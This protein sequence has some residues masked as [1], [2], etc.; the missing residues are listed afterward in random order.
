MRTLSLAIAL[1]LASLST[2]AQ[3]AA[4]IQV[5]PSN[6]AGWQGNDAGAWVNAAIASLP[7][8]GGNVY[9]G[10]GTYTFST[11]I[12]LNKNVSLHGAGS[13]FTI[14]RYTGSGDAIRMQAGSQPPYMNGSITGI[15]L[16]GNSNPTAVGIHHI[17]TIGSIYDDVTVENFTGAGGTGMW[18]DNQAQF[19]ERLSLRKLSVYRNTIGWR[20]TNSNPSPAKSNSFSYWRV[21]EVHFQIA[22]NQTAILA[23]GAGLI[24]GKIPSVFILNGDL[25]ISANEE[26][27]TSR[28]ITLKN[29]AAFSG[30]HFDVFAEC[31]DCATHG[32]GFTIDSTSTIA[33]DGHVTL[34]SISNEISGRYVFQP[35][36]AK[37]VGG[38]TGYF[39]V[40]FRTTSSTSDRVIIK[41]MTSLGHCS[42]S[43]TSAAAAAN[44]ATTYVSEKSN[45]EII[46]THAPAAGLTYDIL[47]TPN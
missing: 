25:G 4:T 42:I 44:A 2:Y 9:L 31:T 46:V 34:D 37:T 43:P 8:T 10:A 38:G 22:A 45:D 19:S 13:N 47:C 39:H 18:F 12:I 30:Y 14:L 11:T 24:D 20:F 40:S 27:P 3:N 32:R 28:L 41:G 36:S 29:G 26:A 16:A 7:G 23:D 5:D 17:D 21:S 33:C 1:S 6:A 35:D 15:A